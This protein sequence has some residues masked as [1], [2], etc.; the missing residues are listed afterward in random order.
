MVPGL[1]PRMDRL[2]LHANPL[3]A[4]LSRHLVVMRLF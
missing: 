2:F 3:E 1:P 4:V